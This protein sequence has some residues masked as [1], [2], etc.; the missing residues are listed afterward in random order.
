MEEYLREHSAAYLDLRRHF[1]G[2][3]GMTDEERD[4]ID[5]EMTACLNQCCRKIDQLKS[6]LGAD[7]NLRSRLWGF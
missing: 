2:G 1:A 5:K 4:E 3:S 6:D 7:A